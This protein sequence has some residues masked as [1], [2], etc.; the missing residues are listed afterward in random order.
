MFMRRLAII[1]NIETR[2]INIW[3]NAENTLKQSG[4][5]MKNDLT[6]MEYETDY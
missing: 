1:C 5:R 4:G 6:L 2:W 3:K